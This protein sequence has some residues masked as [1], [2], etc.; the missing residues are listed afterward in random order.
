MCSVALNFDLA[1]L[2]RALIMAV[3]MIAPERLRIAPRRWLPTFLA[4]EYILTVIS[5]MLYLCEARHKEPSWHVMSMESLQ[6]HAGRELRYNQ[7]GK[8]ICI[9]IILILQSIYTLADERHVWSL[10]D[11]YGFVGRFMSSKP[12]INLLDQNSGCYDDNC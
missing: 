7:S 11:S 4:A 2:S 3:L 8:F 1:L 5:V 6:A 10:G 12:E 9:F